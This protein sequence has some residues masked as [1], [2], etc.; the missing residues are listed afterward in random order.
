MGRSLLGTNCS[1]QYVVFIIHTNPPSHLA[2]NPNIPTFC[3]ATYADDSAATATDGAAS[4]AAAAYQPPENAEA[5]QFEA[6]VNRML[7]IVVNSL[8]T[9]K[10][11]FLREVCCYER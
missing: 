6:E 3:T 4:D 8:Y 2:L 9:N 11:V 7:D 1:I 5:F 10:D